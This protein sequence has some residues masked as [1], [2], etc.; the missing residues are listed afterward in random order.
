[1][2]LNLTVFNFA[3]KIRF[4]SPQTIKDHGLDTFMRGLSTQVCQA[5][6]PHLNDPL[7]NLLF[8]VPDDLFSRNI[9]R[10]RD[11]GIPGY[12]SLRETFLGQGQGLASLDDANVFQPGTGATL[13]SLYNSPDEVDCF[14]GLLSELPATGAMVGPTLQVSILSTQTHSVCT[15]PPLY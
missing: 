15:N 2:S 6:D 5:V 14:V 3:P 12:N 8:G 1:M 9:Q 7:R 4:F 13:D 11:H 10:A